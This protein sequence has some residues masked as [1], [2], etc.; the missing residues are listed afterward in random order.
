[1][2]ATMGARANEPPAAWTAGATVAATITFDDF[3]HAHF[4]SVTAQL[5][6]YTGDLG[7]AQ[8]LAQEAFCRALARWDRLV[9]YDDPV[10]W[11]RQVA[12]NLA[13]SRWRRLRTARN[14]LLR[15]RRTEAEVAGPTPDR[16]AIDTA[17]AQLPANHRRAVILHYL[18]DLPISQI[19]AQEGVAEGTVKSWLHRGRTALAGLLDENTEGVCDV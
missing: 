2:A 18:A 19:A 1:M 4:G 16:V 5:S 12:W 11:V 6:A 13:R 9:R 8:D 3:Y 7:H 14:H 15:Q 10:A 17:L